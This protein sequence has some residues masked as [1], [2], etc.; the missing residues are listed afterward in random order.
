MIQLS[1]AHWGLEEQRDGTKQ[2]EN[3]GPFVFVVP[4]HFV[5]DELYRNGGVRSVGPCGLGVSA[6]VSQKLWDGTLWDRLAVQV[7][8][9]SYCRLV[10]VFQAHGSAGEGSLAV[11]M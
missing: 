10:Q 6:T 7:Q 3:L 1:R 11:I 5:P 9:H 4:N 2:K 8:S